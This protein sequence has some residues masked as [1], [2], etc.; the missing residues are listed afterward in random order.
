MSLR[1][2]LLGACIAALTIAAPAQA[3]IINTTF[4]V[5]S[6][7]A[8]CLTAETI[9]YTQTYHI[10]ASTFIDE[11]GD[12]QADII[13]FDP[14][15]AHGVGIAS[16]DRYIIQTQSIS[17]GDPEDGSKPATSVVSFHVIDTGTG[18]DF[19]FSGTFHTTIG[20]DGQPIVAHETGNF[21]CGDDHLH[22][23]VQL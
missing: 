18:A 9:S 1:R 5:P 12:E 10:V 8:N 13:R 14:L 11:N 3:E 17:T 4:D 19:L 23:G 6:E 15:T 2:S 20:A 7:T 16:G 22:V 21:R